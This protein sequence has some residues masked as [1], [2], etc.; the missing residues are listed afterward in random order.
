MDTWVIDIRGPQGVKH[1]EIS[2]ELVTNY[3]HR[4]STTEYSVALW[5]AFLEI[6]CEQD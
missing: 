5:L 6:N 1:V 3:P 4:G 2:N